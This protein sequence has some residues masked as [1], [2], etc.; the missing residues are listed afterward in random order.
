MYYNY[1]PGQAN[2]KRIGWARYSFSYFLNESNT[3]GFKKQGTEASIWLDF[4]TIS[5]LGPKY[6]VPSTWV[7]STRVPSTWYQVLGTK[8]LVPSTWYQVLGTKYLGTKYLDFFSV[9]PRLYRSL[10]FSVSRFL[11]CVYVKEWWFPHD[12][13]TRFLIAIFLI[14]TGGSVESER[15]RERER[16]RS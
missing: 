2:K 16:E 1:T 9:S 7:P 8:Y 5:F 15:A 14:A 6:L 11:T 10:L 13:D 12:R 3:P 4:L